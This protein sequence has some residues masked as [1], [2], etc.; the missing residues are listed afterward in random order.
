VDSDNNKNDFATVTSAPNPRNS[1]SASN[2]CLSLTSVSL[3]EGNSGTTAFNFTA[4]LNVVAPATVTFNADTA[5][6][7]ATVAGL[8][9][10]ALTSVPFSIPAGNLSVTVPV[11][12]TGDTTVEPDETFTVTLSSVVGANPVRQR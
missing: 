11:Q 6:G 12:V 9:Y 4:Q 10:T 5:N 1:A 8:D 2:A 3:L 7:T